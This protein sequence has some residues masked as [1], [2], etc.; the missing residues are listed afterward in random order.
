MNLK[1]LSVAIALAAAAS[2]SYAGTAYE[3]RTNITGLKAAPSF[4]SHTFTSCG[5]AGVT[6]PSLSDCQSAYGTAW[7]QDPEQF[8]ILHEGSVNQGIQSWTVPETGTYEI[9]VAG[10]TPTANGAPRSYSGLGIIIKGTL[11]LT[12]GEKL[13]LMVGQDGLSAHRGGGGSFVVNSSGAPILIAG[14]GGGGSGSPDG[15]GQCDANKDAVL[16]T[17][18]QYGC[19]SYRKAGGSNGNGGGSYYGTG[20]G[21]FS[22]NSGVATGNYDYFSP[23]FI[24]VFNNQTSSNRRTGVFGGGGIYANDQS[25]RLSSGGGGGYSGGGTGFD[26]GGGGASFISGNVTGG[27]AVGQNPA[28]HGHIKVTFVGS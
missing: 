6:G 14:G 12:S 22:S 27:Q 18:G 5:V 9:E 7:S 17:T 28:G 2:L 4:S 25:G 10:A 19:G 26:G 24:Y 11:S 8:T 16:G 23:S 15:W 1:Q 20:G 3:F 21:G 13:L